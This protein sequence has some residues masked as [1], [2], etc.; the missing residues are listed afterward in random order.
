MVWFPAD[1]GEFPP[2]TLE[3]T[4]DFRREGTCSSMMESGLVGDGVFVASLPSPVRISTTFTMQPPEPTLPIAAAISAEEEL[5]W[6]ACGCIGPTDAGSASSD[7]HAVTAA[8]THATP[9]GVVANAMVSS[10][11]TVCWNIISEDRQGRMRTERFLDLETEGRN[12]KGR[13]GKDRAGRCESPTST[14]HRKW[15]LQ[16]CTTQEN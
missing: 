14:L 4:Y 13:R 9:R 2:A 16:L 7:D 6:G 5:P 12:G 8:V 11:G 1:T 10:T 15:Q 3:V